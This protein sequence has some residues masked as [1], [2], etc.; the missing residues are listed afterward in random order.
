DAIEQMP[1][2]C[3]HKAAQGRLRRLAEADPFK[4]IPATNHGE[5]RIRK[6]VKDDLGGGWGL[7]N[8]TST[9]R[10]ASSRARFPR[11]DFAR[12]RAAN[13]TRFDTTQDVH[14]RGFSF[15]TNLSR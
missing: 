9:L 6:C 4:G 8:N 2:G 3:Q 5:T 11:N 1:G 7:I 12:M 10:S 14:E 15:T 13:L